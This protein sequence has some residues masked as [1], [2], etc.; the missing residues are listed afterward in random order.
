MSKQAEVLIEHSLEWSTSELQIDREARRVTGVALTS[1]HSRNG[2]RYLPE[3]LAEAVTCY[4]QKPIFLDHGRVPVKPQER[5]ARDLV[6]TVT[7]ARFTQ[8]V[9][10]A[11]IDVFATEAGDTFLA[12]VSANAPG[13]GMSHVV[14]AEKSAD[15]ATVTAIHDVVSVDVV[16]FPAT[17]TT[18]REQQSATGT[19]E[20]AQSQLQAARA[21]IASY[22]AQ[23]QQRRISEWIAQSG[24][25]E[26]ALTSGLT[27][28]LR[29]A[30]TE[31]AAKQYLQDQLN[32][33]AMAQRQRPQSWSRLNSGANDE[34]TSTRAFVAALKGSKAA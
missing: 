21:T 1:E 18:F 9:I 2:Y 27:E 8:G 20:A 23:D 19:L 4:N 25:P 5:S 6:G 14:L 29:E 32:V 31:G 12:L 33:L 13:V 22:E 34:T 11:D 24:L 3:A 16:A 10:K 17:T 30:Q 26:F 28:L 15:G 7:N